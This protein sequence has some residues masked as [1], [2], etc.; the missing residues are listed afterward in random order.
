PE[1]QSKSG[2]T[3]PKTETQVD[4]INPKSNGGSGTPDNGQVLCRDC[5]I[6]KSDKIIPPPQ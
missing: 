4:H 6:Q 1:Q 2:V 5:N 3:P